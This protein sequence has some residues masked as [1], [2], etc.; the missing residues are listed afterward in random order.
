M[1]E[2][3]GGIVV[4]GQGQA[5]GLRGTLDGLASRHQQWMESRQRYLDIEATQEMFVVAYLKTDDA[6]HIIHSLMSASI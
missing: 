4:I 2:D 6:L 1:C 5:S 3:R